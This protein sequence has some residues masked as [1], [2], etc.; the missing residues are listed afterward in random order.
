[1]LRRVK[2]GSR[3]HPIL[4]SFVP[5]SSFATLPVNGC[6]VRT[7][8][9]AGVTKVVVD[10]LNGL[11][12]AQQHLLPCQ[13]CEMSTFH[14]WPPFKRDVRIRME[15]SRLRKAKCVPATT[16]RKSLINVSLIHN[17]WKTH[18]DMR[19][20]WLSYIDLNCHKKLLPPPE[21]RH[22]TIFF[23]FWKKKPP[24]NLFFLTR[25]CICGLIILSRLGLKST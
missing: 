7:I 15:V 6:S 18:T 5:A 25:S 23:P 1:M 14:A 22:E 3:A 4:L 16:Y 8:R 17:S 20:D 24:K 10:I 19:T 12:L 2:Q 21:M 13:P 9:S 11:F